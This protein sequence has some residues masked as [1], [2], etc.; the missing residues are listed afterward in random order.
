MAH[1]EEVEVKFGASLTPHQRREALKR[2][3]RCS[4]CQHGLCCARAAGFPHFSVFVLSL[5]GEMA[6]MSAQWSAPSLIVGSEWQVRDGRGVI[7]TGSPSPH[8]Y[9]RS[10]IA[11]T[12]SHSLRSA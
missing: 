12:W 1:G 7:S 6:V 3:R 11:A 9:L 4:Y 10:A 5:R 8:P 2:P